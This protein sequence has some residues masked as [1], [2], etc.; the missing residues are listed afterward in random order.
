MTLYEKVQ[1]LQRRGTGVGIPRLGVPANIFNEA[2]HGVNCNCGETYKGNTGC[3]TSYPHATLLGSTFN[4]SLW[5]T[6]GAAISTEARAFANQGITGLF[7]YAPDI[8]LF[9]DPRWGRGQE[10][11]GED[12]FLTGQYVM[13]YSYN[14]QFGE[15]EKYLKVV[16][17]AKHYADYDQEGNYGTIRQAF[18]ANVSMQDQVEY[19][20]PAWRSAI[21]TGRVKSIMCSYNAVNNVPSCG[22]DYFMNQV[23]RK[24]WGFDGFFVSDCGAIGDTAFKAYVSLLYPNS[25]NTVQ[26]LQLAR[27]AIQGGCDNNC[28]TYYNDYLQQSVESGY[29]SLT[30]IDIASKRVWKRTI[31]LGKLDFNNQGKPS[32]YY[33]TYGADKIDTIEH[34]NLALNAAEQ[35]II[36]LKNEN[37]FL[38]LSIQN[39]KGKSIALIGPHANSTQDMLSNYHGS[40]ILVDSNSPFMAMKQRNIYDINY[41]QGCNYLCNDTK[42]FQN[43]IT[44]AKSSSFA[45]VFLGLHPAGKCESACEAE[46]WDRNT[47]IFPGDQLLLLQQ[48]YAVNKNTI[49]VLINGGQID[50]SW[51]KDN[52]PVIIEAFYPGELGGSAISSIIYGD[53][54]PSGKLPYTIYDESI[55]RTR[56]SIMDMSL[57]DNGGITYRYYTGTPVYNFGFGLYY[58]NFTYKYYNA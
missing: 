2:L 6:I 12:P 55:L 5:R 41:A 7:F 56:P 33:T 19:Y 23:A 29:T 45:I 58:T 31:E 50:I 39:M 30:D 53:V 9:R 49:L 22:N 3:A 47:V 44:V 16:S 18:N 37:N 36:L 20:W 15:D 1:N 43:A 51:P 52:I 14:M 24:E 40:N 35:G 27:I 11:P 13:E 46:G 17:T 32:S 10:V 26:E 34:R 57:R 25:S 54:S 42:D 48:V 8:N 4:R 28:G 38:P 21:Q